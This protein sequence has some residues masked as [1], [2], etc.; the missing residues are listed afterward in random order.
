ML[1]PI[2][3]V[4]VQSVEWSKRRGQ[5]SVYNHPSTY[6]SIVS[7]LVTIHYLAKWAMIKI[8]ST[9]RLSTTL[10]GYVGG[11]ASLRDLEASI[12]HGETPLHFNKY[13]EQLP[14]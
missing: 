4:Q 2:V 3:Q 1:T 10:P 12:V 13:S 11:A 7:V 6:M 9:V 14:S 5:W 8:M